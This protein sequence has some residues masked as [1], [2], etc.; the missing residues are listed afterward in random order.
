LRLPDRKPID[1]AGGIDATVEQEPGL[2][3]T[4]LA[5]GVGPIS[6]LD[7]TA[8]APDDALA[9]TQVDSD[10]FAQGPSAQGSFAKR[11][12]SAR[13][14]SLAKGSGAPNAN[15]SGATP[16]EAGT[17]IGRFLVTGELGAGGMGVVYAAYDPKLDRKVAIKMLHEGIS[18]SH[19]ARL[20][21]EA[22]AMAKL[23]HPNVVSVHEVGEFENRLFVAMEFVDGKTLRDWLTQDT[24]DK[25]QIMSVMIDAGRGLAA[26]H[27]ADMVHRDFKPD[28]VL[29]GKDGRTRVS[30][31]G[32]VTPVGSDTIDEAPGAVSA[33]AVGSPSVSALTQVGTIMGTPLY[34]APEQHRGDSADH[35]ADQFSFCVTLWEALYEHTPY[36]AKSYEALVE[37]VTAGR[38][39]A[40]SSA[41]KGPGW[42]RGILTKGLSVKPGERYESVDELLRALASDPWLVRKRF[43]LGAA[44]LA[45]TGAAA[46]VL[47]FQGGNNDAGAVCQGANAQIANVWTAE[48]RTQI[49]NAFG[50][51]EVPG[52]ADSWAESEKSLDEYGQ[53]WVKL[54]TQSC[55]ATHVHKEQDEKLFAYSMSC[56]DRRLLGFRSVIQLFATSPNEPVIA[57]ARKTVGDLA[58]LSACLSRSELEMEPELPEDPAVQAEILALL[59]DYEA[60]KRHDLR[61]EYKIALEL[62]MPLIARA[63]AIDYPALEAEFLISKASLQQ[64]LGEFDNAEKTFREAASAAAR[65]NNDRMVASVWIR[66]L[67]LLVQKGRLDEALNIETVALT[68]AARVPNELALQ[69][70][71]QNTLGGIYVAKARYEDAY[72]AYDKA[73]GFLRATGD[74]KN[75]ALAPAISNLGLAHWYRGDIKS[76]KESFEE[77]LAIMLR[78]LG[79]DHSQ[80]AYARKNIADLAIQLGNDDEALVHYKEVLRIWSAS[81][82]PEHP[83]LGYAY[84]QLA[85]LSERSGDSETAIAYVEKTLKVR[86]DALGPEHPLIVQSHSVAIEV[87]LTEGS[88]ESIERA[89]ASIERALE[90]IG[91]LGEAG[92]TQKIYVLDSKAKLAESREQWKE[93]LAG[94]EDVLALRRAT[95]GDTHNDTAYSYAQVA[96]NAKRLGDFGKAESMLVAAQAIYDELPNF[97]DR[98]AV[99]MRRSR[100]HLQFEQG[101]LGAA[102]ALLK[103]ALAKAHSGSETKD[104][105]AVVEFEIAKLRFEMGETQEALSD[106]RALLERLDPAQA[107]ELRASIE[108]WLAQ[109]D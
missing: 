21:R 18:S 77:A 30:D 25:K 23:T 50:T 97:G 75:P 49:S 48:R 19:R 80:V 17:Q 42:I 47:V 39:L 100:A 74:E 106:A 105:A 54:R 27:A 81:L 107:E 10:S 59:E 26:A 9:E 108:T 104:L 35:R 32:L 91:T 83:N 28:N 40:P 58:D 5:P 92:T 46:A 89:E 38:I 16:I 69:A 93:A 70:R 60:L 1:P 96:A 22:R 95:L 14:G 62:T 6:G 55:E 78:D 64:T 53:E 2:D 71:L 41:N 66:V 51:S 109:P 4:Q 34:M 36:S 11:G 82:G 12:S 15:K 101:K 68:S 56:F 76:A 13:R 103:E 45:I 3:A 63:V 85:R 94:R 8:I 31:F 43:A 88:P 73:L 72:V 44:G 33:P 65:A 37:N 86:L 24:P 87:F 98:D 84:E 57:N 67:D 7:E 61:G 90:I 20:E 102:M 29:V 52:A 79:P 99:G